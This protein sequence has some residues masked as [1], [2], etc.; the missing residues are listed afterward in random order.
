MTSV[1]NDLGIWEIAILALLREKPMHP[2][3]MQS[4]LHER[5]QDEILILKRG[6]LYHA[7]NRLLRASLIEAVSS[8]REGRRPQRTTYRILPAG[9]RQ[10]V[11]SLREMVGTPKREPSDFLASLNFIVYLTPPVATRQLDERAAN[12][13][14]E[15]HAIETGL[16]AALALVG[17]IHLL[18]IEYLLAMRQAELGW[19][20]AI[21]G[22]LRSGSLTWNLQQIFKQIR[23]AQKAAPVKRDRVRKRVKP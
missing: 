17:R 19:V 18:E 21:V 3:Q 16:H 23:A 14:K 13:E 9:R 8:S 1:T 20:R 4:L 2:Y 6:S 12:L 10:L 15:I 7:I 22:Q 11:T 5:H